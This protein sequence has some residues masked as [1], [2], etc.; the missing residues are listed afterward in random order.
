M[1]HSTIKKRHQ[2]QG[3]NRCLSTQNRQLSKESVLNSIFRHFVTISLSQKH[4][5]F[6]IS[7]PES[8]ENAADNSLTGIN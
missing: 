3:M 2:T 4:H 8:M 5:S 7:V 1:S 6:C